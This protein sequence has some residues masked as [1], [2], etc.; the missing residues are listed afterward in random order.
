M[1]FLHMMANTPR[2]AQFMAI[3]YVLIKVNPGHERDV[4]Y[5]FFHYPEVCEA[6]PLIGPYSLLI[7]IRADTFESLGYIVADR[8]GKVDHISSL[9]ILPVLEAKKTLTQKMVLETSVHESR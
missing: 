3:A 4:Y 2:R 8:L 1:V 9:E 5:T 7:K 6:H